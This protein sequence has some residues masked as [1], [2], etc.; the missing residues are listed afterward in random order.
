MS[1]NDPVPSVV[2]VHGFECRTWYP[3]QPV[4]CTICRQSGH[5]PR[6]YN[7]PGHVASEC[8]QAWGQPRPS[9]S[10]SVP[11]PSSSPVDPVPD[12]VSTPS[13]PVPVTDPV[14]DDPVPVTGSEDDE[15]LSSVSSDRP[16]P[17]A[18]APSSAPV[19]AS[20]PSYP[21]IAIDD[22]PRTKHVKRL[23]VQPTAFP[24]SSLNVPVIPKFK[25]ACFRK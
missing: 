18:P 20:V 13:D 10:A 2:N 22:H 9:S 7:Q 14:A 19:P 15:D 16:Y 1:G 21:S 5:L 23:S 8:G 11:S 24:F 12:P 25:A 17:S 3:G 4:H 6:A